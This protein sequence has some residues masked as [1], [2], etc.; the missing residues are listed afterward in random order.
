MLYILDPG[1]SRTRTTWSSGAK[2][3]TLFNCFTWFSITGEPLSTDGVIYSHYMVS[4]DAAVSDRSVRP[5][6]R[7]SDLESRVTT[8]ISVRH[9]DP[10]SGCFPSSRVT[11]LFP[12][13]LRS[14]RSNVQTVVLFPSGGSRLFHVVRDVPV[15]QRD[16]SV[17]HTSHSSAG[18]DSHQVT[19][20]TRV[21]HFLTD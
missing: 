12:A 14:K 19:H 18:P 1:C 4:D 7:I 6:K 9:V 2:D 13:D 20:G 17:H 8:K 21:V 3:E 11:H 15:S 5:E 16:H 10:V